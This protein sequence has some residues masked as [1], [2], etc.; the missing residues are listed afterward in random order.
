MTIKKLALALLM[1]AFS[2]SAMSQ[3]EYFVK[4]VTFPQGATL[5]QKVEMASRVVPNQRQLDWQKL[6]LTA[7]LHFGMNTFTVR[8]WGDGKED[9]KLFNPTNFDAEQWV[10]TLKDAG[11][12]LAI[13]T[14]KHH[15]GFCLWPTATTKHSVASSPWKEGKGDVVRELADACRKHGL[16]LGIYLSP[17]DRNAPQ[18][19]SEEYND[20]F[21]AQLTELLT[22]YGKVDEVWFDGA[23]AEGPNGKRQ[24]YDWARFRDTIH[25]LQPDAVN[26]IMGEDVRWVGNE[27]GQG[28]E[29]EWSVT[30]YTPGVMPGAAAKNEAIGIGE[31]SKD[32]GSRDLIAKADK[33]YWYPS[34]VDV[35]IRP[36]WFF[37]A[38]Q[39]PRPLRALAEIYLNSVGR[40]AVLLLNIP[41]DQEGRI[42]AKDVEA[43]KGLRNWIDTNFSNNL[44][45]KEDLKQLVGKFAKAAP[46]NTIM[47]GEDITKGQRVESFV[48]EARVKGKWQEV[49]KGTTI[50][51]KRIIRFPEV[52][53]DAL[54][55]RIT[56]TRNTPN[57]SMLRAYKVTL[58]ANENVSLPGYK[59]LETKEWKGIGATGEIQNAVDGNAETFYKSPEPAG[60]NYSFTVD[61]GSPRTIAGF[62]YEPRK[63][64]DLS[65]TIYRYELATSLDGK[66]WTRADV[67]GEFGNIMHNPIRQTVYF[68]SLLN[69]RYIRLTPKE[70]IGGRNFYTI[71]EFSVLVPAAGK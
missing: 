36:G 63:G 24:V 5:D 38:R 8:E 61:M 18:Y 15:D 10:K 70:E 16:K 13:I 53:A 44:V 51:V 45:K 32:L 1:G 60:A 62:T 66:N 17:W 55:I 29:T 28:R 22:N 69:A 46:V 42:N 33:L 25:R 6:E 48:V 35:S 64:E 59:A 11:F 7:F 50:G 56:G 57:I 30:A 49:A 21:V 43:L 39:S 71:G 9:P 34:E 4:E 20:L 65:G 26:A 68:P 27:G 41:P 40:N 23:C 2:L 14:A 67:S 37:D 52:K 58:P 12:K 19:G 54:R 31:T 47:T 3:T